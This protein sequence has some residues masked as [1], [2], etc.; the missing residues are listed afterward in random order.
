M[1]SALVARV[2][3]GVSPSSL[4]STVRQTSVGEARTARPTFRRPFEHSRHERVSCLECHGSGARHRTTLVRTPADCASC[5]H[6]EKRRFDCATCHSTPSLPNGRTIEAPMQFTVSDTSFTRSLPFGH[7]PH[8]AAGS[9]ITCRDCHRA[10]VTLSM[11]RGCGSCHDRH[12]TSKANCSGCHQQ[13][14]AGVHRADVHLSCSG[15]AGGCHAR[16]VAPSPTLSRA[17]CVTC[18][19]EQKEH[20]PEGVCATCHKIPAPRA[21]RSAG[22]SPLVVERRP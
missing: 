7:R 21:D 3:T 2:A 22:P 20:E 12:H 13:P 8:V 15:S 1:G 17:L 10:P 6:D 14:R 4:H 5:H 11:D 9:P 19:V 18:H 16:A